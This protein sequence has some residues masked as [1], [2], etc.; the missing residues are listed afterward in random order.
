MI[1]QV[2]IDY[3]GGNSVFIGG[4][5]EGSRNLDLILADAWPCRCAGT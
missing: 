2:M 5:E 4:V 1:E 3:P